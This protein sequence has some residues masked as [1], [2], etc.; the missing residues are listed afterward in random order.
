ME[1][2]KT[3]SHLKKLINFHKLQGKSIGFVP[4]MGAIHEGHL[5]LIDRSVEDNEIT[6]VSIFVNPTQFNEQSDFDNYPRTLATDAELLENR[7]VDY[8]FA[9]NEKEMYSEKNYISLCIP[10][11]SNKL[12]GKDRPGHF[13]GVALIVSKLFNI[14]QPRRAYFGQKDYQQVTLVKHLVEELHFD[15]EIVAVPIIRESDGL[16]LSSRNTLLS[17]EAREQAIFLYKALSLVKNSLK[18]SMKASELHAKVE[19]LADKYDLV[20]LEYFEIVDANSLEN[21]DTVEI[22]NN[23]VAAISAKVGGIR[24]IDNT[25]L[26]L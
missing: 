11:I 13:E 1:V 8:V 21:C 10:E 19:E 16:A 17:E 25:F 5:S 20:E 9:P 22:N 18:N 23:C 15:T 6:V 2:I 14:V 26:F 3:I 4:T 7:E 12:C 24:L